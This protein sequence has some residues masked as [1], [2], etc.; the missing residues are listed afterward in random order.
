MGERE[1]SWVEINQHDFGLDR[2][3]DVTDKRLNQ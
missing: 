3:V 2:D 1:I